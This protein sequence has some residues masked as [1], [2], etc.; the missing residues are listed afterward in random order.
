MTGPLRPWFVGLAIMGVLNA[1]IAAAYY[2]RVVAVMYF[3]PSGVAP[4]AAGGLR[5]AT[6]ML[7]CGPFMFMGLTS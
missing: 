7:A 4:S 6:A 2:L 1:A 5:A 3:R